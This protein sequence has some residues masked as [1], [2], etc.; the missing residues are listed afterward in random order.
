MLRNIGWQME[1]RGN[2]RKDWRGWY[3]NE[4][5]RGKEMIMKALNKWT[6]EM[7][8]KNR[9]KLVERKRQSKEIMEKKKKE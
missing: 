7:T 8:C 3:S 4:C 1:K 9:Y 6:R 5:R 2:E